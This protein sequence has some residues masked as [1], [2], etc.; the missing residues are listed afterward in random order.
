M[1]IGSQINLQQLRNAYHIVV[2]CYGS[3]E[4][5]LLG[6]DGEQLSC[7]VPAKRFVGWYNGVPEDKNLDFSLDHECVIII[8]QGNV[9]LD[10]ARILLTSVDDHLKVRE[11][12][13]FLFVFSS[14]LIFFFDFYIPFFRIRT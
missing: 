7:V 11:I 1:A 2:L 6:I 3:T 14:I 13:F 8:G 12:R 4:D 10:C 9:A 5:R